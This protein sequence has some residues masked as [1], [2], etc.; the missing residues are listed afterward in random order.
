LSY[1]LRRKATY[2]EEKLPTAKKSYLLRRKA[3]YCEEMRI[4]KFSNWKKKRLFGAHYYL[5]NRIQ[6]IASLLLGKLGR[7][8]SSLNMPRHP[9]KKPKKPATI[10]WKYAENS[11][12]KTAVFAT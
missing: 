6:L 2:Y 11:T 7:K 9:R 8:Y 3:T 4:D 12:T 5:A 10:A 1:L